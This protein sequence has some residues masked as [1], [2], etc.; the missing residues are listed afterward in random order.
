[1]SIK[2]QWLERMELN[3]SKNNLDISSCQNPLRLKYCSPSQIMHLAIQQGAATAISCLR[4]QGQPES[5]LELH[6]RDAF[7]ALFQDHPSTLQKDISSA[8]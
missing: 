1:M 2:W 8:L 3:G 4:Q 6:C 7:D 5:W